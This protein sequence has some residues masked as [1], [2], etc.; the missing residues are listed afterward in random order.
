MV[1]CL[2]LACVAASSLAKT[3]GFSLMRVSTVS[4]PA[5][6]YPPL[7]QRAGMWP[8]LLWMG[9]VSFRLYSLASSPV[10]TQAPRRSG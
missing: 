8:P 1:P 2:I 6:T 5:P 3:S 9:A 7:L 10:P 4:Q